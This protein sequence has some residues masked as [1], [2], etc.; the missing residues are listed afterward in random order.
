MNLNI[1]TKNVDLIVERDAG[2]PIRILMVC[3][4]ALNAIDD[5]DLPERK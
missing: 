2:N 3:D 5:L 4:Y 1:T